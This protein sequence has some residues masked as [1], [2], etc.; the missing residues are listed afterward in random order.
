MPPPLHRWLLKRA[1]VE[2]TTVSHIVRRSVIDH[3]R[4]LDPET[5]DDITTE[6]VKESQE[7]AADGA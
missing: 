6:L 3:V 4:S 1:A 7:A 2:C 5:L